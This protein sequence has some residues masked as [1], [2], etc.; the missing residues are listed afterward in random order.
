MREYQFFVYILASESGT[1]YI[2]MTN[3][4]ERRIREHKSGTIEGFTKKYGCKRLVYFEET[5]DVWAAL[6]REKY[7]KTWNR[8]R[9]EELIAETNPKWK[10]LS[11]GWM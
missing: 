6:E 1:L 5:N 3:D 4:L 2:G 10:D 11:D 7:L 9:K 8:R